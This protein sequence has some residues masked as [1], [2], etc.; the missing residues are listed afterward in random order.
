[1]RK[2]YR[3]FI[4]CLMLFIL[5]PC[6]L[7]FSVHAETGNS[8][9]YKFTWYDNREDYIQYKK[10]FYINLI[11]SKSGNNIDSPVFEKQLLDF[12]KA[13]FYKDKPNYWR[14]QYKK[15]LDLSALCYIA[16]DIQCATPIAMFPELFDFT[17]YD[18]EKYY[19]NKNIIDRL[20]DYP[21]MHLAVQ[22]Q[23]K[24]IP[25]L[26]GLIRNPAVSDRTRIQ[27]FALL[28]KI[29]E[30]QAKAFFA[31]MEEELSEITLDWSLR[32]FFYLK[33]YPGDMIPL[34]TN[35]GC[36]LIKRYTK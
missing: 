15:V 21:F 17:I 22:C 12:I 35:Q 3:P 2:L 10:E 13:N 20:V 25:I 34:I 5:L 33:T 6:L 7:S 1:M 36:T 27:A 4:L 16:A 29:D 19:G 32:L 11:E 30:Y 28:N 26:E 18:Y 14:M 9:K 31:I 23:K 24:S 8:D